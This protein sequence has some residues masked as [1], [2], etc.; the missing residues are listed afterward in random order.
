MST[1]AL[2]EFS[3]GGV[4]VR[5]DEVCVIVP[6]NGVLAL[7]KGG[8]NPDED[9]EATALREVREETGLTATSRGKLGDVHYWYRRR[10]GHRVYKTVAF[11]LCDYVEG[12]TDDHDH[13]VLEARWVPLE[14]ARRSLSYPGEREMIA[15]AL[16]RL[17]ANE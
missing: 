15:L 12:S 16:S 9:G 1:E 4:V 17:A 10:T 3:Y 8:A 2:E 11:Y 6:R 7:P 13:E 5:G 14:E